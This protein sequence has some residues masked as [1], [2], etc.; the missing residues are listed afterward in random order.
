MRDI[1]ARARP[2]WWWKIRISIPPAIG[3][4]SA[5]SLTQVSP[6]GGIPCTNPGF[7]G[8]KKDPGYGDDGEAAIDVEWATAAAPDAAIVLAACE[9][10]TT[11]FGGLI[12]LVNT[13][14]GSN[15]PLPSVVS[16]SYGGAGAVKGERANLTYYFAY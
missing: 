13:L 1:P 15:G 4:F 9:D 2:S 6:S 10:T 14:G 8:K 12:A 3:R 5:G 7:Q 16:I 11:T